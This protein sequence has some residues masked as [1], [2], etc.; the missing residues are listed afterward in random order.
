M[1]IRRKLTKAL[2]IILSLG[3]LSNAIIPNSFLETSIVYA[4]ESS[5]NPS[6]VTHSNYSEHGITMSKSAKWTDIE[7]GLAE[8][9]ITES[10][11][12][13][14]Y[15]A[16]RI[17]NNN[18]DTIIIIDS[19]NS[20]DFKKEG[21]SVCLNPEHS[22]YFGDKGY[23]RLCWTDEGIWFQ[24]VNAPEGD[25][26]TFMSL[27][28]EQ[29]A[30]L[31]GLLLE[32]VGTADFGKSCRYKAFQWNEINGKYDY[33]DGYVSE[34]MK[35]SLISQYNEVWEPEIAKNAY[36][37][38][39]DA[40][41]PHLTSIGYAREYLS[42]SETIRNTIDSTLGVA[43]DYTRGTNSIIPRFFYGGFD[44]MALPLSDF[45][46]ENVNH[47]DEAGNQI[48]FREA[49]F[50]PAGI[51][52]NS[53]LNNF[54]NAKPQT[55]DQ[56]RARWGYNNDD[57]YNK[58]ELA[59][60]TAYKIASTITANGKN[61]AVIP[62]GYSLHVKVAE[63][64][65]VAGK[66]NYDGY[67][68]TYTNSNGTFPVEG[69]MTANNAFCNWTTNMY[70]VAESLYWTISE[71][72]TS[73]GTWYDKLGYLLKEHHAQG[74]DNIPVNI[75]LISDG[76]PTD[77]ENIDYKTTVSGYETNY[78]DYVRA[79][80]SY[81]VKDAD[82]K[83]LYVGPYA[84]GKEAL[85]REVI[86]FSLYALCYNRQ[87]SDYS[88]SKG[89]VYRHI[90]EYP[91]L[92]FETHVTFN[93]IGLGYT[94]IPKYVMSKGTLAEQMLLTLT[95]LSKAYGLAT[96]NGQDAGIY[97]PIRTTIS[98]SEI[99]DVI[100][101]ALNTNTPMGEDCDLTVH[102]KVITDELSQYFELPNGNFEYTTSDGTTASYSNGVVTW[103]VK[104]KTPSNT[105]DPS[106]HT[107]T[108]K[109]KLKDEYRYKEDVNGT[110]YLTN[111]NCKMDFKVGV[112]EGSD[113][114]KTQVEKTDSLSISSP[115]LLYGARQFNIAKNFTTEDRPG[116]DITFHIQRK[117]SNTDYSTVR[118]LT[119]GPSNN[120]TSGYV[121][122]QDSNGR[123]GCP[124]V[125]FDNDGNEYTYDTMEEKIT[126][127]YLSNKNGTTYLNAP[128]DL[129]VNLY[130]YDEINQVP[131]N[132]AGF[133]IYSYN[134]TGNTTDLANYSVYRTST[135]TETDTSAGKYESG[136]LY[137]NGTN[138]GY[139]AIKE[140]NAPH[141]YKLDSNTYFINIDVT[142]D[143]V[144]QSK[145]I[146]SYGQVKDG[147]DSNVKLLDTPTKS[148]ITL[149]KKDP[150]HT[151]TLVHDAVFTVYEW[152]GN[153]S[154]E[155]STNYVPYTSKS[156]GVNYVSTG[157]GSVS[158]GD[159]VTMVEDGDTGNYYTTDW[160]YYNQKGNQGH[161]AIRETSCNGFAID[162][163][164]YFY[165]ASGVDTQ[166]YDYELYQVMNDQTWFKN[167]PTKGLVNLAKTDPVHDNK[168]VYNAVFV[169]YEWNG[170]G[171]YNDDTNYV[172]YIC[173]DR[174]FDKYPVTDEG[175]YV[176]INPGD[177]V[178]VIDSKEKGIYQS[179]DYLYYD[180]NGNQGHFLI[181]EIK[182]PHGY[183]GDYKDV[184]DIVEEETE[185][186]TTTGNTE[187]DA[188]QYD[189]Y[190][191]HFVTLSPVSYASQ[192]P[193][194]F[195]VENNGTTFD[196]IPIDTEI[197][198][199][200]TGEVPE[201]VL[202]DDDS[203]NKITYKDDVLSDAWYIVRATTDIYY[204]YQGESVLAY[205]KGDLVEVNN[206]SYLH[207]L[208][209]SYYEDMME[210]LEASRKNVLLT[211][212]YLLEN[213]QFNKSFTASIDAEIE[214]GI[215]R[216]E[217][218]NENE[219]VDLYLVDPD[220]TIYNVD[221]YGQN[222]DITEN[223]F[224]FAID[225][226]E[227]GN[228]NI[229]IQGTNLGKITVSILENEV[230]KG[231]YETS[232]DSL[233]TEKY[234]IQSYD[235]ENHQIV[236]K[237]GVTTSKVYATDENGQIIIQG[238]PLG[239]YEIIEVKAP[240]GYTRDTKN[241]SQM[242]VVTCDNDFTQ[243]VTATVDFY[244]VRQKIG[245]DGYSTPDDTP[246]FTNPE[247]T[248]SK[249]AQKYVYWNGDTIHY[250]IRVTNTG[251]TDLSSVSVN[252]YF[253]NDEAVLLGTI[254]YLAKGESKD[255]EFEH[256]VPENTEDKTKL[257]NYVVAEGTE[258]LSDEDLEKNVV[259]RKVTDDDE[260]KVIVTDNGIGVIKE[261]DKKVYVAG[262][263]AYYTIT[264]LNATDNPVYN[265]T[266]DDY[267]VNNTL[268]DIHFIDKNIDG[269]TDCGNYVYIDE[270]APNG[271]ITLNY[272]VLIPE[273]AADGDYDNLVIVSGEGTPYRIPHISIFKKAD[274]YLYQPG[275]TATYTITVL[276][277]G[278]VA[279]TDVKVSDIL[280]GSFEDNRNII[281]DLGINESV[282]LKY[283]VE[284]PEDIA[285]YKNAKQI[286]S[287]DN[288]AFDNTDA[289]STYYQIDN[290]ATVVGQGTHTNKD[291]D[292]V[293]TEVTDS[294]DET[295]FV[296]ETPDDEDIKDVAAI[297]VI[298]TLT[299]KYVTMPGKTAT[300]D[301]EVINTGNV[302]ITDIKLSD[303]LKGEWI[304]D[305][306][307]FDLEA[308]ESRIFKYQYVIP[309]NTVDGTK[310]PNTAS[311]T[312]ESEITYIDENNQPQ[313]KK[314]K[315]TD[316]DDAETI[317][318]SNEDVEDDDTN[319]VT[320]IKAS[321]DIEKTIEKRNYKSGETAYYTV[322]VTNN[323]TTNLE[324]VEV[325]DYQDGKF[326]KTLS[327]T[328]RNITIS[329]NNISI[330]KLDVDESISFEYE[331]FVKESGGDSKNTVTVT[332]TT[333]EDDDTTPIRVYDEDDEY[334]HV[335]KFVGVRKLGQSD[336]DMHA[337]EGALI[338]L[339]AKEDIYATA[340][341]DNADA[342]PII[343][344]DTL[345]ETAYTNEYGYAEFKTDLPIG[346]YYAK[347]L[348]TA[349]G[350]YI[351]DA[352]TDVDASS[353][354]Y[355]DQ[356]EELYTGGTIVDAQTVL[357][358][359][360]RDDTTFNELADANLQITD[361]DGNVEDVWITT[362][363]NGKGYA[364]YGLEPEVEYTLT[365][366]YARE[367]YIKYIVRDFIT[368]NGE[369]LE[370]TDD[371]V[372]FIIHQQTTSSDE[373]EKLNDNTKPSTVK[374]TITND[375][376]KGNARLNKQG[377]VLDSWTL[378][379]KAIS[380][381]KS[382]F[383]YIFGNL[384]NV[385]FTVIANE[386]IYHPDG[387][388]GL[389]YHKGDVVK[390]HID[391]TSVD[392]VETTDK[393]GNA[394]F[395]NM[396]LGHYSF[397]ETKGINGYKVSDEPIPFTLAYKNDTTPVVLADEGTITIMNERQKIHIDITKL[398][399]DSE[400]P[401]E[402]ALIGL[403]TNENI[404]NDNGD[405]IVKKDT[406]IESGLSDKNGKVVFE[407]DIP[408]GIYYVKE[409]KAPQYFALNKTKFII[410]VT[411]KD[412]TTSILDFNI[413]IY[414]D[415]DEIKV[416]LDKEVSGDSVVGS[417][418]KYYFPTMRNDSPVAVENATF[419]DELPKEVQ[420][421]S[422]T[423]GTY[424]YDT[425]MTIYYKTKDSNSWT[426]WDTAETKTSKTLVVPDGVDITS[427]K[428]VFKECPA[429][430]SKVDDSS[431]DVIVRE[432]ALN[433]AKIKNEAS[434]S[435]RYKNLF[436]K[437]T[438]DVTTTCK[439]PTTTTTT[440]PDDDKP[441]TADFIKVI[442][443]IFGFGTCL[444]GLYLYLKKKKILK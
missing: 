327:D 324:N 329:E 192:E 377:E 2:S 238:L 313:V 296:I 84:S 395:E 310:I 137:Y 53:D 38:N 39:D 218:E 287:L 202:N 62:F 252:D 237:N 394:Y 106:S 383:Y 54:K 416:E 176:G 226:I 436:D 398:C 381:V 216:I 191:Y 64:T 331:Y 421:C 399:T 257:T 16:P 411:E 92:G 262:D 407:S 138:Q 230:E 158:Y 170:N 258:V 279:L 164:W 210:N 334:I 129:N 374:L 190:Q 283:T 358:V 172:P 188:Y 35:A 229:V 280:D 88:S 440:V 160:L 417:H 201:V 412:N 116:S 231:S 390:E 50:Q 41:N 186:N 261:S 267:Y 318:K 48:G 12:P 8:I 367:G 360:L 409:I 415:V 271:K 304:S 23:V 10:D 33:I 143:N 332:A 364:V 130:K 59:R 236:F 52:P 6:S 157:Y 234:Y 95:K 293:T 82:G 131:L 359:Y 163:N 221:T 132:G 152:N 239:T 135:M 20:M 220:G 206:N 302:K 245:L 348:K 57:C 120:W 76:M 180:V 61:V 71:G 442:P 423:T 45:T 345:I 144:H 335:G 37:W 303:S 427:Y 375:F 402:G 214:N 290:V 121:N 89:K 378:V 406:L 294:D 380:F 340:D 256:E 259:P 63:N 124:F 272:S 379:D 269:I 212:D 286:E 47:Y 162:E 344:A 232:S 22:Y 145:T 199:N 404:E 244:N 370:K 86:P 408:Y 365:E 439:K 113:D 90:K 134:G 444:F 253:E 217:W 342:A 56:S 437:A 213:E 291:G 350:Y 117:L 320:V 338:G 431:C 260:C 387:I 264:V 368:G 384:E 227:K 110:Y 284:I 299:S 151:F 85:S 215:F 441:S 325:R 165:S 68:N 43:Q 122:S 111:G 247:I 140:T 108:F 46:S 109:V 161:F 9:T 94:T 307:P 305:I 355:N 7:A 243:K 228:W 83:V 196:N 361:E 241:C 193:Q 308:G 273:D 177:V 149:T 97:Y 392:A 19:S 67:T 126:G 288:I 309:E 128:Y 58:I 197:V 51:S 235:A 99:N 175:Q 40:G 100:N 204:P 255:F 44:D 168:P 25:D 207:D 141:G 372:K 289:D 200:K 357:Y 420:L 30:Y 73:F 248:V 34:G 366:N 156:D 316:S 328:E 27:T 3:I 321:I 15:E 24:S 278:E 205:K 178:T 336:S 292:I 203:V 55:V 112:M 179:T 209:E 233:N 322:T 225:K 426:K 265:V 42:S 60:Q 240:A 154:Y 266:V 139:F 66:G 410:D 187:D 69:G 29:G 371:Y 118:K 136:K 182:T 285:N 28:Q 208:S 432:T 393:A 356:I 169:V 155:D 98:E 107:L 274:K 276:N 115:E 386:D 18:A 277:D 351:T 159:V 250:D 428:F 181:K 31:N 91:T 347:E 382:I 81:E 93:C 391:T 224:E 352:I 438:D 123:N 317:V 125:A 282:T 87:L 1:K 376:V 173:L 5:H 174:E 171:D 263:V 319:I 389:I 189:S 36:Y 349:K 362:N 133:T 4:K 339:Y 301:I 96:N 400:I 119:V 167:I 198:I 49:D 184:L 341:Y 142:S 147:D 102:N 183:Y 104:E 211:A 254:D 78:S 414:D 148:L 101:Q 315:V 397:V 434:F 249:V 433:G 127:F 80:Q 222:I 311:A 26:G 219:D 323:G 246:H 388:T 443:Y 281:G 403:Y 418:L 424:N 185:L 70:D 268:N 194:V 166:G 74:R 153:G 300:Y 330:D 223:S 103:N 312:G 21:E 422:V 295:V 396:Y 435:A 385:E 354:V 297:K 270:I 77:A 13:T 195:N 413:T 314:V 32:A 242:A 405:V 343:K 401:V 17:N 150:I 146:Y 346:K 75:I 11:I 275:E 65:Y 298:K 353:A 373:N 425:T 72:A 430:F 105:S 114:N 251:D 429:K 333:P 79:V 419:I 337:V 14:T 306:T 363:T 369:I 326:T